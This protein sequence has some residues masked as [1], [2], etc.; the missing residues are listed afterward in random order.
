MTEPQPGR[1]PERAVFVIGGAGGVG[2]ILAA[3][4]VSG[5]HRVTGTHRSAGQREA[6]AASG[7]SPLQVDLIHD[8]EATWARHIAGHDA[9]VF[10]A[11]AHGTGR[12]QTTAIDGR[13]LEKTVKA[14]RDAGVR[15][16]VLVSVFMDALRRQER[17][18]GFEHYLAVKRAADVYL[19]ASDLDWIIVR[20]GTLTDDL[21]TGR[22]S[23]AVA[24]AYGSVSREDVAGV[25]AEI[26]FEPLINH[27]AVELTA[28]ATPAAD[29]VA[30]LRPRPAAL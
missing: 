18:D 25:I 26:L 23:L 27:T 11:G 2:Q 12:E 7:A 9:V 10:S 30:A 1:G 16:F 24:T 14:A 15:R 5:G 22:V 6:V 17:S 20:P 29:A 3:R 4:L 28:G 13:G 8:P 19:A 21:G